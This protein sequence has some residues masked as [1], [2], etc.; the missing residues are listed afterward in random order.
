[1]VWLLNKG[2]TL[3]MEIPSSLTSIVVDL[4]IV[5]IRCSVTRVFNYSKN[6]QSLRTHLL[7]ELSDTK[8]RVLHSVGEAIN[9]REDIKDDVGK[10][11]TSMNVITEE[12]SRVFGDENDAKKRCFMGK[13]LP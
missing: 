3:A 6:V 4:L 11:L 13:C 8:T 10:W 1:M 5:P 7:D 9:R 2:R 12:A